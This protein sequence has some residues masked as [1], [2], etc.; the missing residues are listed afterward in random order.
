[1]GEVLYGVLITGSLLVGLFFLR[2]WKQTRD[3]FF[4]L[5]A[6]AFWFLAANWLGL[7]LTEPADET[8]TYFYLLRLGAFLLILTAII[9]KNRKS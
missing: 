1:M 2:F 9:D 4:L 3:R 6:A 5:F 7:V 8:Q